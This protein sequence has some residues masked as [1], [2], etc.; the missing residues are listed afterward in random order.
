MAVV[1]IRELTHRYGRRTALSGVDLTVETGSVFALIGPNGSGKTT[2]L[3]ILMGLR[4]PTS[5][6][7]RIFGRDVRALD[8]RDRARIGYVAEG[9]RLPGSMTVGELERYLAPLYPN[10]DWTLV[11]ELRRRFRLEPSQR[12]RSLSR[13][14]HMKAALMCALAS[15]PELVLMDE[16]FTGMDVMTRDDLV[17]GLLESAGR[18]DWTVIICTH[19][20]GEIES[21]ADHVGFLDSGKLK[22]AEPMDSLLARFQRIEIITEGEASV[23]RELPADWLQVRRNGPRVSFIAAAA[24]DEQRLREFFPELIRYESEAA[25]LREIFVALA[26]NGSHPVMEE[27]L[28]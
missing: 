4:R 26:R 17:R 2:L 13:G 6:N 25:T 8:H 5:G 19:D 15:R 24:V 3:Q 14:E 16:P 11:E 12:I 20:L 22:L 9:Q 27:A 28:P 1:E 23:P 7:V 10:W 18:D 21:L